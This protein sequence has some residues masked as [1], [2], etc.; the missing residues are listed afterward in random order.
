MGDPGSSNSFTKIRGDERDGY[1]TCVVVFPKYS[2]QGRWYFNASAFDATHKSA[3]FRSKDSETFIDQIGLGDTGAPAVTGLTV[4]ARQVNTQTTS[5]TLTYLIQ[6]T[7]DLS[8]VD[9]LQC[10]LWNGSARNFATRVALQARSGLKSTYRCSFTL[11]KYSVSGMWSLQLQIN[12]KSGFVRSITPSVGGTWSFSTNGV[13]E[14]NPSASEAA[15]LANSSV[16]QVGAGDVTAPELVDFVLS[17]AHVNTQNAARRI[18]VALHLKDDLSGVK[19]V[20]LT[21]MHASGGYGLAWANKFTRGSIRN[22]VWTITVELPKGAARGIW[23]AELG[24]EDFAG[25]YRYVQMKS[26]M[27]GWSNDWGD[28]TPTEQALPPLIVFN[29]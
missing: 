8:G 17:T 22:G 13:A 14:E 12:D 6:I 4:S 29:G 15:L 11:P 18:A 16:D 24:L 1:Y 28:L 20:N 27:S 9:Y 19:T 10:A 25:H 23:Y 2:Y 21:L 5:K 3:Y 26:D 7:D